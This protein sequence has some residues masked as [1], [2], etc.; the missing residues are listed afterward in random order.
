MLVIVRQDFDLPGK[1][2]PATAQVLTEH[3]TRLLHRDHLTQAFAGVIYNT[4]HG[5]SKH[6]LTVQIDVTAR[7]TTTGLATALNTIRDAFRLL[8]T[9]LP[10]QFTGAETE[11]LATVIIGSDDLHV[12]TRTGTGKFPA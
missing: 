2:L 3:F 5:R 6:L 4:R 7:D 1:N 10:E 12:T 11:R 9:A 8:P